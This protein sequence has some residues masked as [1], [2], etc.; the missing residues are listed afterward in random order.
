[1]SIPDGL[2]RR[3]ERLARIAEA[4]A[5]IEARVKARHARDKAS[6]DARIAERDA[7]AARTGR[8]PRGRPPTS[9]VEGPLPGDQV[10]LTD[11]ESR[12]MPVAG[13]GF[14]QC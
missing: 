10:N 8:K 5:T 4:K 1:M 2:A 7:K 12:S 9:P 3:E 14:E 11:A 13:G 6:H